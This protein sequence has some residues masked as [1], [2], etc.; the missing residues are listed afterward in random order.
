MVYLPYSVAMSKPSRSA[1]RLRDAVEGVVVDTVGPNDNIFSALGLPNADELLAKALMARAIRR[2]I[3]ER[4]LTQQA[5]SRVL[6]I[7]QPDVS[8]LTRGHLN[9]FSLDRLSRLLTL[10][11]QDVRIVVQPKPA[12]RTKATLRTLVRTARTG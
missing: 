6:G 10:L 11:G 2:I 12:S 8:A 5:A 1:A 7:S 4:G 9:G 3:A